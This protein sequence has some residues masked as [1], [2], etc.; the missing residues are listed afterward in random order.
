MYVLDTNVVSELRKVR[1]GRGNAG[2]REWT[3][4]TDASLTFVSVITI[5]ELER[6]TLLAER[7]D[8]PAGRVLRHWLDNEIIG[9]F[10]QRVLTVD[11]AVARTAAAV[12]VPD[13]AP[14]LD[15]LIAATAIINEM[16]VVT[17]N[18]RDFG[19]F[20]QLEVINP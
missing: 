7:R 11:L 13:P 17:R 9:A 6:G 12:H 20:P 2:V 15:T 14:M 16:T 8:P 18:A 3:G 5:Q 1:A 4:R 10:G 19:R